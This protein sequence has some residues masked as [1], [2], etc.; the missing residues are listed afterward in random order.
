[1]FDTPGLGYW[2]EGKRLVMDRSARLPDRC[3]KCNEPADGYRRTVQLSYVSQKALF[4]GGE[5]AMAFAKHARIDV[6]LC[7][8][9]RRDRARAI[10]AFLAGAGALVA[11]FY[12]IGVR[13]SGWA[14]ALI[15][16]AC[17]AA[18]YGIWKLYLVR[19]TK[20]D[21]LHVCIS[22][23]GAPFLASLPIEPSELPDGAAAPPSP[24][25]LSREAYRSARNGALTFAV[26]CLIT[27][28][29]YYLAT[30]G[31]YYIVWGAV[32]FG[33]VQMVR[34][35]RA[36]L[37]VPAAERQ[38]MQV[39]TLAAIVVV[40]A[41]ALGSIGASEVVASQWNSAIDSASD[42]HEK[43][44]ALF[45]EVAARPGSW[46]A[47]DSAD[48]VRVAGY[49]GVA[50]DALAGAASPSDRAW[51]RDGMVKNLREGQD[52]ALE[53]SRLTASSPS[54]SFDALGQRWSA[55][56]A[57]FNQLQSRLTTQVGK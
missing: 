31:T 27:A 30:G 29:T 37:R 51:Y 54:S 23:C 53:L 7:T 4:L 32:L 44:S 10:N 33:L 55:R 20:M 45:Q 18:V 56:V 12:L 13:Q 39:L 36:Y 26:G 41:L 25:D 15:L 50:A 16:A 17:A 3:V 22:G 35:V 8:G 28:G 19:A 11:A 1:M 47:Q 14:T 9:H 5:I 48:M 43:G 57:D 49:Y 34:G 21:A 42:A 38:G 24:A 52:I 40:G 6:P 46:T 2:R